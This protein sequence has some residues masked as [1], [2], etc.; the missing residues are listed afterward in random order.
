MIITSIKSQYYL[1]P[2]TIGGFGPPPTFQLPFKIPQEYAGKI[3]EIVV[4]CQFNLRTPLIGAP[5]GSWFKFVT[6]GFNLGFFSMDTIR[7]FKII[8][9]TSTTNFTNFLNTMAQ[10]IVYNPDFTA[11]Q[12]ES[13]AGIRARYKIESLYDNN[14]PNY[15][16]SFSNFCGVH[17][18]IYISYL[19]GT[20]TTNIPG[21]T[22]AGVGVDLSCQIEIR[23]EEPTFF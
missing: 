6:N 8:N 18:Q 20:F 5:A 14:N 11:G 4:D 1:D 15:E 22:I 16:V 3:K 17:S 19:P 12:P 7:G 23:T 21:F 13:R 10:N 9:P 2:R